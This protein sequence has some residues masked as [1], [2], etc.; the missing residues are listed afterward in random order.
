MQ[1]LIR[2]FKPTD[3]VDIQRFPR[4]EARCARCCAPIRGVRDRRPPP[5][6]ASPRLLAWDRLC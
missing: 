6:L 3:I 4:A 1:A 5:G 2:A